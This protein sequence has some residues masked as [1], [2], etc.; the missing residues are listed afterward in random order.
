VTK[1]EIIP[2]DTVI[3]MITEVARAQ[4]QVDQAFQ[5]LQHAKKRLGRTLGERHN[6]LWEHQIHE[7]QLDRAAKESAEYIKRQ[8]WGS[9]V[10]R[11]DIRELMSVKKREALNEQLRQGELPP[12]T[13]ANVWAFLEDL[14]GQLGNLLMDSAREIFDWLRPSHN[15][16]ELKTNLKN[17]FGIGDKVIITSGMESSWNNKMPTRVD[18]YT[19][20]YITAL[21]NVMHLLDGK[22]VTKHPNNLITLIAGAGRLGACENDYFKC[23][24]FLNRNLHI[25]FK[26][27]DLIER[28]N[29]LAGSDKLR[30]TPREA[31]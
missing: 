13:E 30:E 16:R 6:R 1:T 23:K 21:D 29:Q 27:L 28:L 20:K 3:Q 31:S 10:A 24:W 22:G 14:Y 26:R 17:V 15:W 18:S 11:L 12:L 5:L 4:H 8:A 2:R 25:T 7:S 9:I 19:E